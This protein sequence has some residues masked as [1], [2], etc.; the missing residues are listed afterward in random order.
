LNE[1][2][3]FRL[4]VVRGQTFGSGQV[5]LDN[6][7]FENCLFKNCDIVYRGGPAET[8]ACYFENVRWVFEGVAGTIV[9]VVQGLGWTI[10]PPQ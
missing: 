4:P 7:R 3:T 9:H 1:P 5:A 10:Q 2:Q 6:T 8:S